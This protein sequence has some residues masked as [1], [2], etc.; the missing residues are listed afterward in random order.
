MQLA[1]A[2]NV[3]VGAEALGGEAESEAVPEE[4]GMEKAM[5]R[6]MADLAGAGALGKRSL[7]TPPPAIESVR[8]IL[9]AEQ[10]VRLGIR[11]YVGFGWDP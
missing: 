5:G 9:E 10:Q 1:A 11:V 2:G 4:M 8:K 6:E 7:P 3:G